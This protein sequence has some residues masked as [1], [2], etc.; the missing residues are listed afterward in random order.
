MIQNLGHLAEAEAIETECVSV[1]PATFEVLGYRA[2]VPRTG[3]H[4]SRAAANDDHASTS[5]MTSPMQ[6]QH[7]RDIRALQ[8]ASR[9]LREGRLVAIPTE[10]VYG[11]AANALDNE[12]VKRIFVAKGRPADNPLIIHVRGFGIECL[13]C[14]TV[15]EGCAKNESFR[16][17]A[18]TRAASICTN[19]HGAALI[20]L[21][22]DS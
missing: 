3:I 19:P 9:L 18:I 20:E 2:A 8:R 15:T 21:T 5:S 6:L 16:S 14:I 1:D 12:A 10:T 7:E 22:L 4:A 17:A 11:L 13:E